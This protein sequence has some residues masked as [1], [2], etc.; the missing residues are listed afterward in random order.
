MR[1]WAEIFA[2][3]VFPR[4]CGGCGEQLDSP[5]SH[6][7]WDCRSDIQPVVHP[8]CSV[9]GN[10][11]EGRMDHEFVCHTCHTER[12]HFD[13][14]RCAARY[15]GVLPELI[16]GL[17]YNAWFWMLPDLTD[18][19]EAA[20]RSHYAGNPPDFI[21]GV[22]LFP[23]RNRFRTYN[24]SA[25]LARSLARRLHIPC[26]TFALLRVRDT[27]T[28]THLT[29]PERASNVRA[30]FQV[31]LPPM[32]AGRRILLIDDVMTTGAT[33]NE[34]ARALKLAGAANVLVLTLARG[35]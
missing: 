28:Q 18:L 11:F 20:Y 21:T 16:R 17:K 14:A 10:P 22:P 13:R 23:R 26:R 7:C 31:P 34:C 27:Q 1:R 24:Q 9:C 30:A 4:L 8:F 5:E 3:L 35:G 2:G 29:A 32:V 19:L 6:L 33:V 25:L 15:R 12:P